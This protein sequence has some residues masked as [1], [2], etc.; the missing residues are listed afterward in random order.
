MSFSRWPAIL[1]SPTRVITAA[2]G[3]AVVLLGVASAT[4]QDQAGDGLAEHIPQGLWE[5]SA[6]RAGL[7]KPLL[8][9][10]QE[11]DTS[12]TCI[13]TDPR[14]HLLDWITRKGCS[15]HSEQV[16]ADG[17]TLSGSCRLK[18]LPGRPIPVEVRLT[19]RGEGRFDLDIRSRENS[20]LIYTEHTRATRLGPCEAAESNAPVSNPSR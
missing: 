14:Q 17:Y 13:R 8:W 12:R 5:L 20:L 7:F 6:R 2:A 15:V 4:A 19:W 16:L 10:Y 18:W 11:E 9:K 1:R 3:L